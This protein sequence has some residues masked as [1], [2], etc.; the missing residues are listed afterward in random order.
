MPGR[1]F[2][3]FPASLIHSR[4]GLLVTKCSVWLAFSL[5]HSKHWTKRH[6]FSSLI[7]NLFFFLN[8]LIQF[9]TWYILFQ[10]KT[11]ITFPNLNNNYFGIGFH[12]WKCFSDPQRES[13][14]ALDAA[15]FQKP[16]HWRKSDF[17]CVCSNVKLQPAV[18]AKHFNSRRSIQAQVSQD[19][20]VI[21]WPSQCCGV[22]VVWVHGVPYLGIDGCA[23]VLIHKR[24]SAVNGLPVDAQPLAHLN[25]S[26]LKYWGNCPLFCRPHVYKHVAVATN[27]FNQFCNQFFNR[28]HVS[29]VDVAPI[30]G[31]I[32]VQSIFQKANFQLFS[33]CQQSQCQWFGCHF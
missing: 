17:D 3:S 18:I 12:S 20:C 5:E 14:Q 11:T 1:N 29:N 7:L 31:R 15:L 25:Q 23:V 19:Q 2:S 27:S 21:F 4:W 24:Q 8:D 26:L 22:Y 16:A 32:F 13:R 30:S 28:Q 10:N 6:L 9:H 33:N